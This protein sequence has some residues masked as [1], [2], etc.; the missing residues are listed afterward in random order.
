[1]TRRDKHASADQLAS[2]AAGGRRPRR[3]ARIQAHVA[4]C[5]QCTRVS[6]QLRAIPAILASASYPP[7]PENVSARIEAAISSEARQRLAT[8]SASEARR[9][10]LPARRRL[11]AARGDWHLPGLS[12]AAT[13]LTVVAGAVVIA[14]GTSYLVA[15]MVGTSVTS[16]SSAAAGA[17][18]PVQSLGPEV[19][20]GKPGSVHTIRVVESDTNFV[21][22]HLRAQAIHAVHAAEAR[23]A[24]AAQPSAS[25]A[26][27]L[28]R[29]AA[30]SMETAKGLAGCIE[31]IAPGQTVLLIDIARYQGKPAAVI[32]T[33]ATA[34]REAE[35][36]VVGPSCS[37][38]T[39][40][41]LAQAELGHL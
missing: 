22:A 23:G 37:A 9:H 30:G 26:P 24:H 18:A 14:A 32:V 13:R 16:S 2:L 3:A 10:A 7:M 20:Y 39:K 34:L 12:V 36:W 41:V 40:D 38:T 27:P 4:Q 11:A 19:T 28:T 33:A 21:A 25:T 31:L 15:Q 8:V 17:A 1:M 6:Q 35:A 29:Q 5:G